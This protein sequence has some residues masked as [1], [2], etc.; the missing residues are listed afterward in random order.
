MPALAAAA[1]FQCGDCRA[2]CRRCRAVRVAYIFP[3]VRCQVL[4]DM[5]TVLEKTRRIELR[6]ALPVRYGEV[7]HGL[8]LYIEVMNTWESKSAK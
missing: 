5:S 3:F 1:I 7:A 2:P 4:T 6:L 8:V